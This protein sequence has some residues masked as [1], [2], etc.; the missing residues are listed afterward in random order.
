M[1]LHF[2]ARG[3]S[4]VVIYWRVLG[5]IGEAGSVLFG[6]KRDRER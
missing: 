1:Q 2:H 3:N 6:V 5:K 4:Q